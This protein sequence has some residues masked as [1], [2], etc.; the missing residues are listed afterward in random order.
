MLISCSLNHFWKVR[1]AIFAAQGFIS[2]GRLFCACASRRPPFSGESRSLACRIQTLYFPSNSISMGWDPHKHVNPLPQERKY[3][4][5]SLRSSHRYD[6]QNAVLT[7][8]FVVTHLQD[9]KKYF[10]Y[11]RTNMILQFSNTKT[12]P[13]KIICRHSKIA[14]IRD[15]REEQCIVNKFLEIITLKFH[16]FIRPNFI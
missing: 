15:W 3:A 7:T 9:R 12:Q 4:K 13:I 1:E 10:Y 2:P 16:L 6:L 14:L 8:N 5:Y 11:F